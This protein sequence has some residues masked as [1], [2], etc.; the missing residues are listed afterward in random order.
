MKTAPKM[1]N[2]PHPIVPEQARVMPNS[3]LAVHFAKTV[4]TQ[5]KTHLVDHTSWLVVK[6]LN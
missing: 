6:A 1:D 3:A 5:L 2:S 4:V